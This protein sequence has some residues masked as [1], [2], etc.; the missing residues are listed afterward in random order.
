MLNMKMVRQAAALAMIVAI[1]SCSVSENMCGNEV[2][3]SV[4]SPDGETSA[5]IFHRNCGAT[6]GVNIQISI[7]PTGTTP[8][9]P[10][11]TLIID[12]APD[13][14][15]RYRPTWKNKRNI[16]LIVPDGSRVFLQK[17]TIGDVSISYTSG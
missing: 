2:L 7:L 8:D 16:G 15:S 17:Q 6:T 11:N 1:A 9:G 13:Y 14:S 4:P 5:V 12:G 3:D 10:G